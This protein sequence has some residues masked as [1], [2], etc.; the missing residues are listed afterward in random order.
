MAPSHGDRYVSSSNFLLN[1]IQRIL[2]VT[3]VNALV[4]FQPNQRHVAALGRRIAVVRKKSAK[5]A[6]KANH[7]G[8]MVCRDAS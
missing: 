6:K 8:A 5:P 7:A 2:F 3:Q 4:S 1:N